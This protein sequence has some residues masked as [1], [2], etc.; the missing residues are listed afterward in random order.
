MSP[1]IKIEETRLTLTPSRTSKRV[2]DLE[3]FER[4][5]AEY[6][7]PQCRPFF[8]ERLW[9]AVR[10]HQREHKVNDPWELDF[11]HRKPLGQRV[12]RKQRIQ[13]PKGRILALM[14]LRE[15]AAEIHLK[16]KGVRYP[17]ERDGLHCFT[18]EQ[19]KSNPVK[20]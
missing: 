15:E 11:V 14:E 10:A 7:E 13:L 6:A 19:I 18:K 3:L 9:A 1:D 5:A 20:V 4:E 16:E 17:W 2:V 8:L 12:G